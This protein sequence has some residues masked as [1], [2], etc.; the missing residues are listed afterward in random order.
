MNIVVANFGNDSIGLIQYVHSL[1]LPHVV[2]VSIDTGFGNPQWD[3]RVNEAQTW[4][5]SLGLS[6]LRLK[7]KLDFEHLIKAQGEFPSTKFQWCA[8]YLKGDTLHDWLT[9]MD[10]LKEAVV[11]LARRRAQSPRF[12]ELAEFVEGSEDFADRKIWHPLYAESNQDLQKRVSVSPFPWVEHRS[13]E[14]DPCVNS[15]AA[16]VLRL[17]PDLVERITRLEKEMHEPFLPHLCHDKPTLA[18]ALPTLKPAKPKFLFD[19]GCGSPYGCGL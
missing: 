10:P 5:Q 18:E 15:D 17:T 12:R 11:L 16:D 4:V 2:V 6:W 14:C 8:T 1:S 7:P 9:E 3:Q 19:M 13:L